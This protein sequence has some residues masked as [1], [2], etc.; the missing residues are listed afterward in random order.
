MKRTE[1][2]GE[3]AE[4]SPLGALTVP[5][6]SAPFVRSDYRC[7]GPGACR[8]GA[9]VEAVYA[10][11]GTMLMPSGL[12]DLVALWGERLGEQPATAAPQ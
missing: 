11:G 6:G 9:G 3:V 1:E 2:D 8:Q 5:S 10:I 4:R 7:M 12:T